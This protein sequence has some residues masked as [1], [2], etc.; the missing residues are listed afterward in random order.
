MCEL[1]TWSRASCS[2][3]GH[4]SCVHSVKEL[5]QAV[6]WWWDSCR[7]CGNVEQPSVSPANPKLT[8]RWTAGGAESGYLLKFI[9]L[10]TSSWGYTIDCIMFMDGS[11]T[12]QFQHTKVKVASL[13]TG[14]MAQKSGNITAGNPRAV[15]CSLP[16]AFRASILW[17]CTYVWA[18]LDELHAD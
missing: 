12:G 4:K 16:C 6:R 13:I 9:H 18:F 10:S 2:G 14:Q 15:R 8:N 5:V 1:G 7:G 11:H 17:H 3:E